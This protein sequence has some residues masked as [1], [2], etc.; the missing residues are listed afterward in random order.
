MAKTAAARSNPA[1]PTPVQPEKPAK[2]RTW[3]K[4]TLP[5]GTKAIARLSRL[6]PGLFEV[7]TYD[8]D[9]NPLLV[10]YYRLEPAA[11]PTRRPRAVDVTDP[12]NAW[13]GNRLE[14]AK[15]AGTARVRE[16][17]RRLK[18]A[19][20][21]TALHHRAA[22]SPLPDLASNVVEV[23]AEQ[24][25]DAEGNVGVPLRAND[26]L[27]IMRRRERI[28]KGQYA[29]GRQFETDYAMAAFAP[30]TISD[31]C[32]IPGQ[33]GDYTITE[34]MEAKRRSV[35]KAVAAMGG[36]KSPCGHVVVAVIGKGVTLADWAQM[37]GFRMDPKTAAGIL[38]GGLG[39]LAAHYN[40]SDDPAEHGRG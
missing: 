4:V 19:D 13:L 21:L 7:R 12:V 5:D 23:L 40:F 31:P 2:R 9:K 6:K 1:N 26:T 14:P 10:R 22:K 8:E 20:Q 32:R 38:I 34:L 27:D 28:T 15:T 37:H 25:Q 24:V 30:V 36:M 39:A 11:D 3:I 35:E 33:G 18:L 29:A 17:I 16:D